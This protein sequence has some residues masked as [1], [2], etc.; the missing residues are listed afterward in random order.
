MPEN[1]D[2]KSVAKL[3]ERAR[4]KLTPDAR[5]RFILLFA[6]FNAMFC[7]LVL[8]SLQNMEL[9]ESLEEVRA[10]A[11][12][13]SVAVATQIAGVRE[14]V[15]AEAATQIASLLQLPTPVPP[16]VSPTYTLNPT[17]TSVPTDTP[18][19]PTPT[20]L[21]P[22]PTAT[23]IPPTPTPLPPSPTATPVPPTLTATPVPPTPT[24]TPVPPPPTDTPTDTPTPT[25]PPPQVL[26]VSPTQDDNDTVINITITGANFLPIPT[27]F[28]VDG[29]ATAL[30]T[31]YVSPSTLNAV[32]PAWFTADYYDLTVTNPDL[33]SYTLTDAFTLTN[34][35]PL[36]AGVN[37]YTGTDNV[38]T[39]ITINGSNFI[40]GLSA[41]LSAFS[42][43]TV[44]VVNSTTLNATVPSS[45][46][47]MPGGPYTLTI[48]NPGP[49][50]PTNSLT[51]AFTV[52]LSSIYGY[53]PTCDISTTNCSDA[54]GPP[55]GNPADIVEGGHLTFTF[56]AGS[57]IRDG[58]GY[59]F[60]FFEFPNPNDP[61]P[62]IGGILLDWIVV[63][64]SEDGNNWPQVFYWGD[65]I[66]DT[67]TN[68]A[69]HN[70]NGDT[71]EQDNE[72]IRSGDLWP[73]GLNAN[74]GIAIDINIISPPQG[75]QY[76]YI[77]FSC[78]ASGGDAAHMD[79]IER[80]H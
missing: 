19:P 25:P 35:T 54:Y 28:M 37:P 76:R 78:P 36:I 6:L 48:S 61:D 15:A 20:L 72:F 2:P 31:T 3:L 66:T 12:E 53:T 30:E 47:V 32:I 62:D 49:L 75:S 70:Y 58:P 56:P 71:G 51:D 24:D 27:A 68:V 77:R 39:N 14:T 38:D 59:D 41:T 23:P 21:P 69:P 60:V 26:A 18:V 8:L 44:T 1:D 11:Q 5:T 10:G 64:I 74:T 67:N 16:T 17:Y 65:N 40:N 4:E 55:D 73:G 52:T 80:L 43:P 13:T 57:G 9:K 79:S 45:S 7:L 42:L 33:Q 34:P 22:S 29:G 50:A 63:N 46:S